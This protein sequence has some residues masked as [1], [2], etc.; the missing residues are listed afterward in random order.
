MKGLQGMAVLGSCSISSYRPS[1]EALREML[2][3]GVLNPEPVA[4]ILSEPRASG[5]LLSAQQLHG[6]F[7]HSFK[8]LFVSCMSSLQ[9]KEPLAVRLIPPGPEATD[10]L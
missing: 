1:Q 6:G 2:K 8:I 4:F 9:V 3:P 5:R 10:N 7:P